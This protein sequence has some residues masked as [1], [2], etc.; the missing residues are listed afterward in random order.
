MHKQDEE[1]GWQ[2][3]SRVALE[4]I[5]SQEILDVVPLDN[6]NESNKYLK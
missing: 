5:Q 3:T 1:I 2:Q 6:A 4:R